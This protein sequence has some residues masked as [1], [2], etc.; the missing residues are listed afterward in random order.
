MQDI[1]AFA[2]EVR[3]VVESP[4]LP[5]LQ[6]SLV[7]LPGGASRVK[8]VL[9]AVKVPDQTDA[10]LL[11]RNCTILPFSCLLRTCNAGPGVMDAKSMLWPLL[12]S[13]DCNCGLAV[14]DY[15]QNYVCSSQTQGPVRITRLTHY[16]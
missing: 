14:S 1:A 13:K 10:D 9:E 6:V 15:S 11:F 8:Q 2:A 7:L 4:Y 3:R 16:F 12:S 5:A